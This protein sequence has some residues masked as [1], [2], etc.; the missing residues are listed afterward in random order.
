M[1][2]AFLLVLLF[3]VFFCFLLFIFIEHVVRGR[4]SDPLFY[5]DVRMSRGAAF[6]LYKFNIFN[7]CVV[8]S[9]R[10]RGLFIHTK[11]LEKNGG[12]I[13]VG[14][15][16]KQIYMDELPQLVN[17]LRGDMSLVGPRPI[18]KEVFAEL[19]KRMVPPQALIQGGMTGNFQSYKDTRGRSAEALEE[20]YL[21]L[22]R[23]RSGWALVLTDIKIILRTCKVLARAQGI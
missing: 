17:V 1:V 11:T 21:R 3:P 2:S 18:N 12:L 6:S 10:A 15:V 7:Q 20:D 19:A 13:V 16:L 8:D 5:V 22:Y 14:T 4:P 23:E 9:M